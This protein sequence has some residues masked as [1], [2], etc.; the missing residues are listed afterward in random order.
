MIKPRPSAAKPKIINCSCD[1]FSEKGKIALIISY[2]SKNDSFNNIPN[3]GKII[4]TLRVSNNVPNKITGI[5]MTNLLT[6]FVDKILKPVKI[7]FT[8]C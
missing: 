6:A 4:P 1:R 3:A 7:N 2:S 8:N 5:K